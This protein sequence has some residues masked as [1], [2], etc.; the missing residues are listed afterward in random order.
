M[1]ERLMTLKSLWFLFCTGLSLGS[2]L[3]A[4]P[5]QAQSD[6]NAASRAVSERSAANTPEPVVESNDSGSS[7]SSLASTDGSEGADP[8]QPAQ[9]ERRETVRDRAS[10]LG[11]VAIFAG[12][13]ESP[14]LGTISGVVLGPQLEARYEHRLGLHLYAG[15]HL[16][17]APSLTETTLTMETTEAH[18]VLGNPYLGASHRWGSVRVG[19]MLFAPLTNATRVETSLGMGMF[20]LS[21]WAWFREQ[22]TLLGTLE[23]ENP[24]TPEFT[25]TLEG[26]AGL[27]YSLED[28][29]ETSFA[30]EA[31]A[32][33]GYRLSAK[34][35]L[36]TAA[37]LVYNENVPDEFDSSQLGLLLGG[38]WVQNGV[39][40][41][42]ALSMPIDDPLGFA[43]SNDGVF[44]LQLALGW[45]S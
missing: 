42:V 33:L 25:L 37:T 7:A 27:T 14:A 28:S 32:R 18:L 35:R 20:S 29:S 17:L 31:I 40:V 45:G 39:R 30:I 4:S 44:G 16:L 8:A 12:S 3:V 11:R 22:L 43:F 9:V 5:G 15:A 21:P 36:F 34:L 6:W 13:F 2:L 23:W 24:I 10:V 41:E 19:G 26:R 1:F 38:S